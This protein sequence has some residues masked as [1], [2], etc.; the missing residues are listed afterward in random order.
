MRQLFIALSLLVTFH[1]FA[2]NTEV[3]KVKTAYAASPE[4]TTGL[5]ALEE[6]FQ[7]NCDH[8]TISVA[9]G[10]AKFP[11]KATWKG[12]C[13]NETTNLYVRIKSSFKANGESFVFKK[14]WIKITNLFT[15]PSETNEFTSLDP[16][17][18]AYTRSDVVKN[19]KRFTEDQ[20]QVSCKPGKAKRG[21]GLSAAK[22]KYKTECQSESQEIELAV[23]SKVELTSDTSFRFNLKRATIRFE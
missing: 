22:F 17:V 4:L 19:F 16:F 2:K 8:A 3:E 21:D 20:Y 5:K 12:L 18:N 1:S 15:L 10:N 11:K 23:K 14:K 13:H 9:L 6:H 7:L